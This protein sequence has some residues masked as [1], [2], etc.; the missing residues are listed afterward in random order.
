M[1]IFE[2]LTFQL[3]TINGW[4]ILELI[5]QTIGAAVVGGLL[6]ALVTYLY[7]R[8]RP[9]KRAKTYAPVGGSPRIVSAPGR[10]AR[11]QTTRVGPNLPDQNLVSLEKSRSTH[12]KI[13][14][15]NESDLAFLATLDPTK[16]K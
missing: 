11:G 14:G 1:E 4:L 5:L 2:G 9:K 13:E 7:L 3:P 16:K 12:A 8:L 10:N 15:Y 6:F